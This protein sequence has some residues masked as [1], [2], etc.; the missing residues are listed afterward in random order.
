MFNKPEA[1]S[2]SFPPPLHSLFFQL[3]KQDITLGETGELVTPVKKKKKKRNGKE[4]EGREGGGRGY[5]AP[6]TREELCYYYYYYCLI[7]F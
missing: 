1:T 4:R 2:L 3:G 6:R 5:P 7:T